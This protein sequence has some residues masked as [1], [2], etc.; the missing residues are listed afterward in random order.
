MDRLYLVTFI[1]KC[2]EGDSDQ[3]DSQTDLEIAVTT[4]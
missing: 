4:T 3:A 2:H 1:P